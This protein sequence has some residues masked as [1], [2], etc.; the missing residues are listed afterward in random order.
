MQQRL[1]AITPP[2]GRVAPGILAVW[3]DAGAGPD[4]L[5]ISLRDPGCEPSELMTGRLGA[6]AVQAR[7]LG[8]L[9]VISAAPSQRAS[10]CKAVARHGFSGVQV[11]G[12][13]SAEII[14][15]A[16]K[17]L[18]AS[19]VARPIVGCSHHGQ[20][21]PTHDG[22][23]MADYICA[24]PV[25]TPTTRQPGVKKTAAGLEM[26]R[27]W[28]ATGA[29]VF[30]LGGITGTSAPACLG[31][32]A[33]GLAGIGAFFGESSQVSENVAHLVSALQ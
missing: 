13:P 25:F 15:D 19:G 33:W 32:G 5:L 11:K 17:I 8:Y 28:V 3:R 29:Q 21:E 23:R 12:D 16:R 26:L 14:A 31:V 22:W 30:A 10:A 27:S 4:N 18:L 2:T 1:L 6:F 24:A 7:A 20:P 9:L